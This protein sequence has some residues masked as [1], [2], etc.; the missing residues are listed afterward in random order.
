MH[1]AQY[2]VSTDVFG[3]ELPTIA[4]TDATYLS[5]ANNSKA[6]ME[7]ESSSDSESSEDERDTSQVIKTRT[8]K[9]AIIKD[10]RLTPRGS[11]NSSPLL[12][13]RP[14]SSPVPSDKV[15]GTTDQLYLYIYMHIIV[16]AKDYV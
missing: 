16:H 14:K 15:P 2:Y 10:A 5:S 4:E 11:A 3:D 1:Y 8:R 7:S 13:H 12:K 6:N 9:H